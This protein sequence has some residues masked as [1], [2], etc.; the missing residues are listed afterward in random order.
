[1]PRRGAEQQERC[2]VKVKYVGPHT[3]ID[4][5]DGDREVIIDVERGKAVDLPDDVAARLLEQ[6]TWREVKRPAPEPTK[7]GAK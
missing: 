3:V 2:D 1:M 5:V 6:D 7:T 4:V